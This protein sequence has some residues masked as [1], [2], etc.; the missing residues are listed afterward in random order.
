MINLRAAE[1]EALL[2]IVDQ[3]YEKS[4]IALRGEFQK[5]NAALAIAA[6]RAARIEI[7]DSAR[8]RD[9]RMASA[10]SMLGQAHRHRRRA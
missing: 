7:D 6:I 4:P 3:P 10:L 8:S 1:S 9:G 2:Q 5:V